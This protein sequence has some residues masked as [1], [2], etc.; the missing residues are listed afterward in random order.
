MDGRFKFLLSVFGLF[1]TRT[2]QVEMI[3]LTISRNH[4]VGGEVT[5]EQ[6][7]QGTWE[8]PGPVAVAQVEGEI[9]RCVVTCKGRSDP[10]KCLE[11]WSS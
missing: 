7:E 11:Q 10:P 2:V 9:D 8:R 1:K 4:S 6:W 3:P 5:V